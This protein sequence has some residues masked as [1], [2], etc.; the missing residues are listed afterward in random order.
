MLLRKAFKKIKTITTWTK[1]INTKILSTTRSK[2][3]KFNFL[4]IFKDKIRCRI[5]KNNFNFNNLLH[6]YFEIVHRIRQKKRDLRKISNFN[7]DALIATRI[8][9]KNLN[10]FFQDFLILRVDKIL[11]KKSF[12]INKIFNINVINNIIKILFAI[13]KLLFVSI[14][15]FK[16]AIKVLFIYEFFLLIV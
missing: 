13:T 9:K 14:K 12:A 16:N 6:N 8:R 10:F 15:T 5:Y 1:S 3:K 11:S 7:L 4:I 2:K